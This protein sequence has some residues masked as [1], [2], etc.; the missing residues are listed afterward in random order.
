LYINRTEEGR[1]MMDDD[2]DEQPKKKVRMG[3]PATQWISVYNARRP[4]KQRYHY[5]VADLRL[6]QHIEKGNEDGLYISSVASC[7]N[8]WALIMDAG[9]GFSDQVYELSPHFL[10]KE[11]IM[12]QWEKNYYISAIA[13]ANNGSSLIVMSKGT[14]YLQQSYKV[15]ESFPFKW[16]NK[17]WREK[18][19]TLLPWLQLELDGQLLCLVGQ[20]F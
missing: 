16:I 19:F 2:D 17:K 1:L 20:V 9:T 3:M 11:W 15:S 12:E 13:G 14:P 6:D 18:V 8:L 5:N 7:S 10:H 4:M